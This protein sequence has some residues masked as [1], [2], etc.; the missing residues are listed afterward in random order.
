MYLRYI[1][2]HV[3]LFL[4]S[5]HILLLDQLL[6]S[7]LNHSDVWSEMRLDR[8]DCCSYERLVTHRFLCL[9][10]AYDGSIEIMLSVTVDSILSLLRLL[11]L[12]HIHC[13]MLSVFVLVE[14]DE[15]FPLLESS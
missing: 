13:E 14:N 8:I 9:H 5:P 1:H 3:L 4:I 7:F 6:N 2:V 12:E 11:G 15:P 10:N